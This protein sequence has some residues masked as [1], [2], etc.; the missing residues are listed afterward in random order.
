[1]GVAVSTRLIA[2]VVVGVAVS[3]FINNLTYKSLGSHDQLQNITMDHMMVTHQ[4]VRV[5]Y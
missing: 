5:S 2:G 1:M 4:A 3:H